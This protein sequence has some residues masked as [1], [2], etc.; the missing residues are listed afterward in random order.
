MRKYSIVLCSLILVQALSWA[1]TLSAHELRPGFL[2][3]TET[4]PSTYDVLWKVPMRGNKRLR[5]EPVFP[6]DCRMTVPRT[7]FEDG[8]ASTRRWTVQC[9]QGLSGR[10]IAIDGLSATLT[11]VLVRIENQDGSSHSA[12][13]T[14]SEP[15]TRIAEMAGPFAVAKSYTSLGIEHI[16]LGT[17]HL[18]FVF[19]LLLLVRGRW[20]LM[21]TITA[22]TVAHSVTLAA[23]TLD[24]VHVPSAPVEAI[25]ALSILFL[26][27]ELARRYFNPEKEL[28]LTERFP[29]VVAFVFGLLHGFG[30]AGALADI[31][32]PQHA[33]PLALLF[34]NLGVEA[35]QLL[36]VAA[37]LSLAWVGM[38]MRFWRAPVV[39]W[40]RIG[41][42]YV[43]GSLASFWF[44]ER[45][46]GFS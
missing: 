43:I 28:T 27:T 22:F 41:A 17:D 19:A 37:V 44:V 24:I 32:L 25:I 23:A 34:F 29:W 5:M 30:F 16:L 9:E 35:G 45:L 15:R 10:E 36:F 8:I 33:I 21:K 42:V 26:A 3:L 1:G 18:L 39:N 46:T 40:S 14:F 13:L 2:S 12:R 11:D 38:H 4:T 20:L 6:E 7:Y 31:G